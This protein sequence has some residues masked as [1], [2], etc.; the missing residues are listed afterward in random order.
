VPTTPTTAPDPFEDWQ[1]G[2]LVSHP[3]AF[4]GSELPTLSHG[5]RRWLLEDLHC[6]DPQ[7][8][9]TDVRIVL[10]DL[11]RDETGT[12]SSLAGTFVVGLP[13]LAPQDPTVENGLLPDTAALAAVWHQLTSAT[14]DLADRLAE[15][16][17]RMK[18]LTP[19]SPAR[20]QPAT[21]RVVPGRNDPCPCGSGKK[22][23]KCCAR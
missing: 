10:F 3:R 1:P 13:T 23:K 17:L 18:Q 21:R 2:D 22:W 20:Q 12:G 14:P 19:P 6:I 4:P 11:D 16:R 5:G 8:P 15:R 9:C 7:C